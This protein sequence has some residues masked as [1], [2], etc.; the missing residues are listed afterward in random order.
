MPESMCF[1]KVLEDESQTGQ[2]GKWD[3]YKILDSCGIYAWLTTET[4]RK[5]TYFIPKHILLSLF[6]FFSRNE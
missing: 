4:M 6:F 5:K 2:V 1:R 3:V